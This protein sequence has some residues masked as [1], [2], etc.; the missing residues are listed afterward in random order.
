MRAGDM[1]AGDADGVAVAPKERWSDIHPYAARLRREKDE[2]LPLILKL[3][4]YTRAHAER[5]RK[6]Q[7]N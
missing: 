2:M 4:S 1:L 7:S 6:P 5:A 3:K